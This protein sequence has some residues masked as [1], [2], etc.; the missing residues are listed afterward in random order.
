MTYVIIVNKDGKIQE[1]NIKKIDEDTL[2]AKA[3]F[4]VSDNFKLQGKWDN[5]K[6]KNKI[7]KEI[8]IFGKKVGVAGRE[9]KYEL[10]PPLDKDLFFGS[11]II[12]SKD[13]DVFVD[14]RQD[15]WIEIYETLFGGFDDI[16]LSEDD[17]HEEDDES[18]LV[19]DKHG[20]EKDGFVVSDESENELEYDS[21][22][23]EEEYFE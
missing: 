15:T 18:N 11:L 5:I 4:K 16:A 3:G 13:E 17:E 10:P 14:L 21:E 12:T 1:K 6:T 23:S 9:N 7:I 8:N 19:L 20:Y 22:L 2:Y